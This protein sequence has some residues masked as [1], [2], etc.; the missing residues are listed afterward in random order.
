MSEVHYFDTGLHASNSSFRSGGKL[1]RISGTLVVA[2]V[3]VLEQQKGLLED[4]EVH[5]MA[6]MLDSA[7][8]SLVMARLA[9]ISE[10][11]FLSCPSL[12]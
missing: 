5:G 3:S 12:P 7:A 4:E 8:G 9:Q 1:G 6:D 2:E 11:F 10:V